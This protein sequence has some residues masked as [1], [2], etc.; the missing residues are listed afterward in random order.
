M[1]IV[2]GPFYLV[3]V[4]AFV[5]GANWI[6]IPAL[7]YIGAMVYGMIQF[8][9]WEFALGMPPRNLPVFFAFNLP[10]LVVPLLLGLRMRRP[11][12]FGAGP[13]A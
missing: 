13:A 2:Y 3:L 5:R 4:Y 1:G 8:L 10:Y 7:I 9:Y 12:P 11:E 6:R